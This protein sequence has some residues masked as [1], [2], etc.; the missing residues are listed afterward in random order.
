M[1]PY[2]DDGTCVIYHGDARDAPTFPRPVDLLLTDPPYGMSWFSQVGQKAIAADGHRQGVR[3]LRQ[4]LHALDPSLAA[5]VHALVF[6]HWESW[7]DFYDAMC[8]RF[9]IRNALV[10]HKA[11]GGMGNVRTNYLRDYEVILYGARG[12]RGIGGHGSFS[13]VLSGFARIQRDRLHPTEKPT[14]L[15]AHLISRHAPARGTVL[16]PFMGSGSTLAAAKRVGRTA[17]GIEIDERYCE[18]A[19]RRLSQD[20]LFSA[21]GIPAEL[22]DEARAIALDLGA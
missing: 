15:L 5:D 6:C 21:S 12:E 3:V 4:V 19:A 11:T 10:W 17:V 2:Y 22:Q 7:P 18:I 8:P 9:Q 20:D 1:T 14:D 13:N 16:D